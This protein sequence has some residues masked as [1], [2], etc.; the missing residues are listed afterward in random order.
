M[1]PFY[2]HPTPLLVQ[3]AQVSSGLGVEWCALCL[4]DV[5]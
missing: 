4:N 3:T 2:I 1:E 5:T